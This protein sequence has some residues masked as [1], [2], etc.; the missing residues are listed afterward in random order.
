MKSTPVSAPP[1]PPA[2]V[3][4]P[5]DAVLELNRVPVEANGPSTSP[6]RILSRLPKTSRGS[7]R[8]KRLSGN[9]AFPKL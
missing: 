8:T 2:E 4:N 1:A 7:K 5:E 6:S 9:L 3:Q